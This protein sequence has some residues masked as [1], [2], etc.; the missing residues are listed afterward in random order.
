MTDP[1]RAL[2]A[3]ILARLKSDGA[4]VALLG[5]RVW[6]QPR[7]D[8]DSPYLVFGRA[9]TRP[10]RAEGCGYE[11]R[12]TL[13]CVSTYGG[14]GEAKAVV[15]AVRA[16]LETAELAP[17]GWRLVDLRV[18]Y[19]DVFRAADLRRTFGVVR[20]RAVTEAEG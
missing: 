14:S 11:H 9:E 19:A 7:A 10:V 5:T 6:D 13:T 4:C 12:L 1:E 17:V 8:P 16:A 15:A 3:A 2:Q 18:T 20:V